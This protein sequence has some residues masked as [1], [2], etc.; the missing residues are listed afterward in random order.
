MAEP[1][2][3]PRTSISIVDMRKIAGAIEAIE[4]ITGTT[5]DYIYVTWQCPVCKEECHTDK[6]VGQYTTPETITPYQRRSGRDMITVIPT[7]FMHTVKENLEPCMHVFYGPRPGTDDRDFGV[8]V[9]AGSPVN[10]N[11]D[12]DEALEVRWPEAPSPKP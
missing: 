11:F 7:G 12:N 4:Q 6:P 9:P 8:I 3:N 1:E 10:P 2:P 5:R